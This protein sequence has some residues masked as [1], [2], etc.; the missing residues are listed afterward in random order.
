MPN[1]PQSPDT[2]SPTAYPYASKE[3]I[4]TMV[5]MFMAEA[6]PEPKFLNTDARIP[7]NTTNVMASKL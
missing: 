2:C 3:S 5:L 4:D 6:M 7:K 1:T